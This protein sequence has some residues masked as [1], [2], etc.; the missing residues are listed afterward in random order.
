MDAD[1]RKRNGKQGV[2]ARA[3]EG[4]GAVLGMA[5]DFEPTTEP[6]VGA[7]QARLGLLNGYIYFWIEKDEVA[8][9]SEEQE[10]G[11]E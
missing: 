4:D 9:E 8:Y 11:M 10:E 2:L 3:R 7:M 6:L 1:P 5:L